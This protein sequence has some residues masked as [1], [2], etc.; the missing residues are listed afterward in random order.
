MDEQ[1]DIPL[2]EHIT[3]ALEY[4]EVTKNILELL[5]LLLKLLRYNMIIQKMYT[6]NYTLWN[7]M[8]ILN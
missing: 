4:S 1:F 7:D 6:P 3:S 5:N 8:H 2:V